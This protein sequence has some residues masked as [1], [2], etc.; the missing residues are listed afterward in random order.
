MKSRRALSIQR[1]QANPRPS[2][3]AA[4]S[5]AGMASSMPAIQVS[6]SARQ[7]PGIGDGNACAHAAACSRTK[8]FAERR[9]VAS[10]GAAVGAERVIVGILRVDI[11][12][13]E[14]RAV[15]SVQLRRRRHLIAQDPCAFA[16]DHFQPR[17]GV[18]IQIRAAA[19]IAASWAPRGGACRERIL[20][21]H[22]SRRVPLV[23][24]WRCPDRVAIVAFSR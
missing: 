4:C 15:A 8:I 2:S 24:L 14:F 23:S 1:T 12:Q 11:E 22:E 13:P 9:V 20:I 16:V 10:H 5:A 3:Q 7:L 18:G 21:L 19:A 6:R 17:A